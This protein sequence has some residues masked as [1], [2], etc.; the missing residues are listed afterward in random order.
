MA[1]VVPM[2]TSRTGQ[3]D[4]QT[5]TLITILRNRSGDR[6]NYCMDTQTQTHT[7]QIGL[8]GPLK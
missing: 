5:D 1:G 3:T 6:S 2:I 8:F 4:R 7:G